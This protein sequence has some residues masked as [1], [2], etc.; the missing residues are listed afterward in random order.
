MDGEN[1]KETEKEKRAGEIY[2]IAGPVVT[3]VG[4]TPRMYDVVFV[5]QENLMGEV[6]GLIREKTIIQV[7]EDTSGVKPGE[8]VIDTGNPLMV[9][10]GPGLLSSIYDGIQRPLT[11]LR[12]K[13]GDYIKRGL[14]AP[15]IDR[16]KMWEFRPL[17]KQGDTVKGEAS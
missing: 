14:S 12:D 6:I 4:L 5:G 10:L 9:E 2:R 3:A 16:E 7:Y 15:G 17:V 8:K 11:I 13:M 1:T